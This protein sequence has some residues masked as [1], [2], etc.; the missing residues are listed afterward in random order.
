[1]PTV[2]SGGDSEALAE[3]Y[4]RNSR[5]F[6]SNLPGCVGDRQVGFLDESRELRQ[7]SFDEEPHGGDTDLLG[8]HAGEVSSGDGDVRRELAHS[9]RLGHARA[10]QF[11]SLIH[12]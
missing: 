7:P 11:L 10:Q 9:P 3:P 5:V 1:M 6:P 8:E 2:R 12:I 4:C